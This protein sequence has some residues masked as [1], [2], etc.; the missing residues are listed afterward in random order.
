MLITPVKGHSEDVEYTLRCCAAKVR[1]MG[2]MRPWKV[3]CLDE[4]MDESTKQVCEYICSEYEFMEIT[5]IG[6]LTEM[7]NLYKK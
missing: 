1:W 2:K 6:G 4:G 5:D 7:L 3:V